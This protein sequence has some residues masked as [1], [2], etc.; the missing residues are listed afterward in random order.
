M[1]KLYFTIAFLFLLP[2]GIAHLAAGEDKVVA[3]YLIDFG[4]T[5][6]N[7]QI[8]DKVNLVL[9]L[10]NDTTKEVIKPTSVWIRIS[11]SKEV[12]FAGTLHP[13]T[14]SVS[15]TYIFPYADNYE[16]T[17]RF[18][19]KDNVLLETDFEIKIEEKISKINWYFILISVSLLIIIGL[20][21]LKFK[22]RKC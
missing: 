4:Y 9:N 14:G 19:G 17:T 5:P 7:P 18:Q 20:I 8:T 16:I 2:T 6:E 13:G 10:V 22:K 1:K 11:S 15:F 21:I 3:G 12:V